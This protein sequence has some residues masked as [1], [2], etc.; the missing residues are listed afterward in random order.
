MS[1]ITPIT[2]AIHGEGVSPIYGST[3]IHVSA[4]DEG[5]GLLIHIEADIAGEFGYEKGEIRLDPSELANVVAV[6]ELLRAA[7]GSKA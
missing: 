3:A 1:K 4:D 2:Y 7:H 5:A 6:A